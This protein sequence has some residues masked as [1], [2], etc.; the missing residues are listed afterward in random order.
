MRG[1]ILLLRSLFV[2]AIGLP[3]AFTGSTLASSTSAD[4]AMSAAHPNLTEIRSQWIVSPEEAYRWASVKNDNLPA[5]TGSQ[6]W[7][8]YMSFLENKLAQYGAVDGVKNSW[9][10]QRWFTSEDNSQWS[11]VSNGTP[12][13]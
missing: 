10:F 3:T 6:E 7:L 13:R 9:Q 1:S 8:N 12:V 5:L 4:L 2:L 11:L